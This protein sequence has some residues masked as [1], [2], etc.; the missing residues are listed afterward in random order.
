MVTGE[1]DVHSFPEPF[2]AIVESPPTL[3]KYVLDALDS[4]GGARAT[5]WAR[6]CSCRSPLISSRH[7]EARDLRR[8]SNFR[9]KQMR[10]LSFCVA[11]VIMR[12]DSIMVQ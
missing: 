5:P 9:T 4:L 6:H 1:Q 8:N 11:E 12:G 2:Y 7:V 3:D 10:V